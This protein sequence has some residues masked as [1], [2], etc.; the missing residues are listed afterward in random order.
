ME[1][2]KIRFKGKRADNSAW[3]FGYYF[4]TPLTTENFSSDDG[5]DFFDSGKK[6]RHII[7]AE[8]GVC[9]EVH[10]ESVSVDIESLN[11]GMISLEEYISTVYSRMIKSDDDA[12]SLGHMQEMVKIILDIKE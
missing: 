5:Q 4:K 12:L 9:Y 6:G 7:A 3:V 10:P 8:Y 2:I 11:R 1:N